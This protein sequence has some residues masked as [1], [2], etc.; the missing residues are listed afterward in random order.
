MVIPDRDFIMTKL[1]AVALVVFGLS[2][3]TSTEKTATG[4]ALIGAGAGALINGGRGAIAGALI[5][6]VAGTLIG[7]ARDGR[8]IYRDRRTGRT[9]RASC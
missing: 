2:A 5:G 6:G 9:Y 1:L 4:G 3:C 8:C 7:K